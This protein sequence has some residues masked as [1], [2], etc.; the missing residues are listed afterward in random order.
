MNHQSQLGFADLLDTAHTVNVQRRLERETAHLPATMEEAL[1]YHRLQIRQHHAAMLAGDIETAMRIRKEAHS[2]ALKLNGGDAG[3]L[4]SDDAT[5]RVLER[6]STAP[7]GIA[8]LWG[9]SGAFIV[10]AGGMRVRVE[11]DGMFGIGSTFCPF[12]GFAARAVDFDRPFLS[13][14]G[15]RSF[16]SIHAEPVPGMTTDEFVREVIA[17]HVRGEL[18]GRLR[19]IKP[20]YRRE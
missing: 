13:E 4:A 3:I 18:K 16:L 6:E 11:I 14:T 5:G 20:E 2:L 9:Q 15:Y 7:D 10:E 8:P 19:G 1:P 12:P 17:A